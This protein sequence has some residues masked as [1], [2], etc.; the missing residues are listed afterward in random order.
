MMKC[1]E[2]VAGIIR[3]QN[4]R[5]LIARRASGKHQSGFW[6][7]P[8]GKIEPCETASEALSRELKEELN[9]E[10]GSFRY[11]DTAFH[12]YDSHE[13]TLHCYEGRLMS[14]VPFGADH[15]EIAWVSESDL[16]TY[17]YSPADR[18]VVSRLIKEYSEKN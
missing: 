7:F 14:G 13:V 9:I 17:E 12:A 8:G 11:Y 1:I 15:D 5:I 16:H 6:E 10:T 2:V 18:S 3:D 4:G